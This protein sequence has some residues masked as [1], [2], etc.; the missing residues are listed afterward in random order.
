MPRNRLAPLAVAL[1]VCM[2][3][4]SFAQPPNPAT[5]PQ[6]ATRSAAAAM[7]TSQSAA[8]LEAQDRLDKKALD[9]KLVDFNGDLAD[10]T[11]RLVWLGVTQA[12]VLLV[13]VFFLWPA[14][15]ESKRAGNIARDHMIQSERAFVFAMGVYAL[16]EHDQATA[17]YNWRLRPVWKN[18][19]DTPTRKMIMNTECV[20]R[21]SAIPLGFAF[22]NPNDQTGTALLPPKSEALGGVAPRLPTR[23]ITPQ[24][25]VEAQAGT[26]FIYLWG[27]ARYSD[28]FPDTPQHVTRF[29]WL[30]S[31]VGDP[32]AFSPT[33]ANGPNTLSFG[34]I[35]HF[36]NNCA[37]DDCSA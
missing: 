17:L 37:D 8:D 22:S 28:V 23:A 27:W 35:H 4:G 9:K 12:I 29:C 20:V 33:N 26:K 31:P 1:L 13:Q 2:P 15:R 11:R 14:L 6:G 3:L 10:S 16:W 32:L 24:D 25:I 19:G 30:I 5:A 34:T 36:E 7:N 21:T 18:S